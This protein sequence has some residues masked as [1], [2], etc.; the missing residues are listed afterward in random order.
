M[1]T[2][3]N[4]L[5]TIL[6]ILISTSVLAQVTLSPREIDVK[7]FSQSQKI[8]VTRDGKALSPGEIIKVVSGVYKTGN[9]VFD[10]SSGETHT[11]DYSYMFDIKINDDGSITLKAKEAS[12]QIGTYVLYVYTTHGLA[13]GLIDANLREPYPAKPR[14]KLPPPSL[15][16]DIQLPDYPYGQDISLELTADEENTYTW[17][18]DGEIHST[19]LGQTSFRARPS[20][21][22]HEISF[23]A[24][25]ADGKV[26]STWSD[27]VKVYK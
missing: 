25:N 4:L 7:N 9:E 21:G 16:Y 11:S 22:E 5:I 15:S 26:V 27:T 19:G 8:F 18:I 3:Q 1:M 23:I 12:L 24:V 2:S 6:G 10:S 17:Y 14:S 20:I 13:T